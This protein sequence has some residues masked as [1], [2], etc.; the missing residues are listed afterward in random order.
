MTVALDISLL[1]CVTGCCEVERYVLVLTICI[2]KR[3]IIIIS[4]SSIYDNNVAYA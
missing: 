1:S 2:I 4:S 3:I